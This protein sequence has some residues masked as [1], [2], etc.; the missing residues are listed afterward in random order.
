MSAARTPLLGRFSMPTVPA[1]TAWCG[2]RSRAGPVRA[3]AT[4]WLVHGVEHL[5]R[6]PLADVVCPRRRATGALAPSGLRSVDA[7]DRWG[8]GGAPLQAV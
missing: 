4:L 6:R 8:L 2:L 3:A 5:D 7:L 1:S